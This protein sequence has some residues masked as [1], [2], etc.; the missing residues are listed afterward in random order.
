MTGQ[1]IESKPRF[2]YGAAL[3]LVVAV[4]L[5]VLAVSLGNVHVAIASAFP[6]L[7][8][9]LLTLSRPRPFRAHFT[10]ET[11]E[12]DDPEVSIAYADLQGLLAPRRPANPFKAGPRSY[13]IEVIHPGGALRIP[14][15]LDVPS[16]DVFGF[17]YRQFAALAARDVHPGLEAYARR[18]QR[19][20]G[21][22]RVLCCRARSH[23]GGR[24]DYRAAVA[25]FGALLLAGVFWIVWGVAR[26]VEGWW[27]GG[28][29][30][31]MFGGL[32]TLLF[33]LMGRHGIAPGALKGWHKAG[34]VVAPDGLALHQGD[35]SGELRWDEVRDVKFGRV[36]GAPSLKGI[37]L[38]VEGAAVVI[39]D[40]FDRPLSY[41]HQ[42]IDYWWRGD[43]EKG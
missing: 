29:P 11:L 5:D 37:V 32:F 28:I 39:A 27:A 34:L 31:V 41:I 15:R 26:G 24:G 1:T 35:L 2:P 22:D 8:A 36:P 17:L 3:W 16:D 13:A 42:Q 33:W 4:A 40:I 19:D 25:F 7:A 23:L 10:D 18:K 14:A 9:A 30:A 38:K 20:F 12:V 43:E 21:E 6:W